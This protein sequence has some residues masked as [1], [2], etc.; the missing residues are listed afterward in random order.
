[1]THGAGQALALDVRGVGKHFGGLRAIADLTFEVP[2]GRIVSLIGPNGAG[3]TTAFN[4]ITGFLRPSTGR[5]LYR[6]I[7]LTRL[8]PAQIAELGVVR[9]FQRTSVFG[10]CSVAENVL[11][12]LHLQGHSGAFGTLLGLRRVR[13]E[14]ERMRSNVHDLLSFVGLERRAQELAANLA[15]GEQRL[16]G[17]AIAL[18]AGPRLLLMDEPAAGLNPSETGAMM[19]LVEQIRTR[20]V[21]VLLV[22]HDMRMVMAIS[23]TVVVLNHGRIIAE[24]PPG[25]IQADPEVIQAYLG[26]GRKHA[27]H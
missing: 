18:A 4:I 1:M 26:Q 6:G 21:T 17:I 5:V 27:A 14:E 22:E 11:T 3:K 25:T 9:T 19:R 13:H 8:P 23:D 20:G 15:Y 10:A 12:G 24:G 7:D 16:L 2:E